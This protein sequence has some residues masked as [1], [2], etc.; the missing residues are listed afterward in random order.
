MEI[1][2]ST[3]QVIR[4]YRLY[5]GIWNNGEK[6]TRTRSIVNTHDSSLGH[7]TFTL[8]SARFSPQLSAPGAIP[9]AWN[10]KLQHCIVHVL[11]KE[12]IEIIIAPKEKAK[13]QN[14]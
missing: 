10:S 12:T 13:N 4:K 8:R 3:V 14:C 1:Q 5:S 2:K 6:K 7:Q 9:E 11:I